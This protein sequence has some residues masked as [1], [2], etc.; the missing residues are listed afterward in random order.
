M[1]CDF[2]QYYHV[3]NWRELPLKLAAALAFG[4]PEDSRT[5]RKKHNMPTTMQVMLEAMSSDYLAY[6]LYA[7]GGLKERP[8]S[9]VE[10]MVEAS[11]E[12]SH[13]TFATGAE[14]DEAYRRLGGG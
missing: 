4:L 11:T 7:M 9:I 13:L 5:V 12:S 6:I 3:L 2:A 10:S 1:I 14:F 8:K